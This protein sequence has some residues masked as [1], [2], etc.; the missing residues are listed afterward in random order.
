MW[1]MGW[2]SVPS[3]WLAKEKE[4]SHFNG[5]IRKLVWSFIGLRFCWRVPTFLVEWGVWKAK[6]VESREG[7]GEAEKGG[8]RTREIQLDLLEW[9]EEAIRRARI[10]LLT[11]N[12][13]RKRTN[14]R[15]SKRLINFIYKFR[16]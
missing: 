14:S 6:E 8:G 16:F 15:E 10:L 2:Q 3:F 1:S 12:E 11:R 4:S 7:E 13:L 5:G 9:A